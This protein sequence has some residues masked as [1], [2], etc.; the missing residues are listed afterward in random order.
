MDDDVPVG[1][2]SIAPDLRE[3]MRLDGIRSALADGRLDES[4]LEA[5]EFLDSQPNH[6]EVLFMLGEALLGM[7]DA[8]L[9]LP[10]FRACVRLGEMEPSVDLLYRLG[11]AS[12]ETCDLADAVVHLR[13]VVRRAPD[14]ADAHFTL[15]MLYE[16][17]GHDADAARATV[18]FE[19][20]RVLDPELYPAPMELEP[21]VLITAL[22]EA[23]G[24]LPSAL[25]QVLSDVPI[26][27]VERPDLHELRTSSPPLPPT[28]VALLDGDPGQDPDRV[29]PP[30]GL[31]V[32]TA[33]LS[34]YPT[35]DD[36]VRALVDALSVEIADWLGLA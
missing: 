32:F 18:S 33:T 20:A 30:T 16:L 34:R 21:S 11:L 7:G 2:W 8:E 4:I 25:A 26:T 17:R 35:F 5:E 1:G 9:A 3:H 6:P 28:V 14:H 27:L 12:F 10:T 22:K 31:R 13:E 29:D 24:Q 15:G 36:A 19:A 23:V